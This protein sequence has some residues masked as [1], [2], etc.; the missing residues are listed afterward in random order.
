MKRSKPVTKFE[1]VFEPAPGDD[2]PAYVRLK[3]MLKM[4]WRIHGLRCVTIRETTAQVQE[5][6]DDALP[7]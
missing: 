2:P 5:T 1:I 7:F 6:E 3:R 4:A